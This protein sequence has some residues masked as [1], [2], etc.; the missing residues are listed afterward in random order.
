[1]SD[2]ISV[3][4]K[5]VQDLSAPEELVHS[6]VSAPGGL[7]TRD[8]KTRLAPL[9]LTPGKSADHGADIR[10]TDPNGNTRPEWIGSYKTAIGDVE[11][12]TK[13][14]QYA[15]GIAQ[16][17]ILTIGNADH[18]V[19]GGLGGALDQ[20]FVSEGNYGESNKVLVVDII[21]KTTNVVAL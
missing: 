7:W 5:R 17:V 4:S 12:W 2:I 1:M 13:P 21:K 15:P 3:V 16:H 20:P 14:A 9:C 6:F 19:N 18:D 10:L 11:V 8:Y